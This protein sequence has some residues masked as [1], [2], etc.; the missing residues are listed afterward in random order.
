M[1]GGEG[2]FFERE[3]EARFHR[4]RCRVSGEVGSSCRC[5]VSGVGVFVSSD[6]NALTGCTLAV[7]VGVKV[8]L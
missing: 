8:K 3:S 2:E 4:R 7:R 5:C 1:V 6:Q